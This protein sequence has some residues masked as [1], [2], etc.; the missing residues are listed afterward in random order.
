MLWLRVKGVALMLGF[1]IL[2]CGGGSFLVLELGAPREWATAFLLVVSIIS[3]LLFFVVPL[4]LHLTL[5]RRVKELVCPRTIE[6]LASLGLG[7]RGGLLSD[8]WVSRTPPRSAEPVLDL[9]Q[10]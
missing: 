8:L 3:L 9:E 6:F 1:P 7:W 5:K 10:V 2:V 4:Y